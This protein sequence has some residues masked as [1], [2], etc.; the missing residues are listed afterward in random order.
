MG[1]SPIPFPN[2]HLSPDSGLFYSLLLLLSLPPSL[3]PSLSLS[4]ISQ[5]I[6]RSA[7]LEPTAGARS[8]RFFFSCCVG[9][10]S[11]CWLSS[12]PLYKQSYCLLLLLFFLRTSV[13]RRSESHEFHPRSTSKKRSFCFIPVVLF[14]PLIILAPLSGL[15]AVT[16]LLHT[17]ISERKDPVSI[18]ISLSC[19]RRA[20]Y[21]VR[22]GVPWRML[23]SDEDLRG[24]LLEPPLMG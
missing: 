16:A 14:A 5:L 7:A 8:S 3:S 11:T 12:C 21:V 20:F 4:R 6:L 2:H 9:L 23:T 19:F 10:A 22:V 18:P 17:G 15:S 1:C 24:L 13:D